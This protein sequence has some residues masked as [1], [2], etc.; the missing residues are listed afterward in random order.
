MKLDKK[1]QDALND[2][3]N[4]EFRSSYQ[5]LAAAAYFEGGPYRG[6]AKWMRFQSEEER[7]H[8]MKLL[9]YLV[10]RRAAVRLEPIPEPLG[11]YASPLDVFQK[12]LAAEQEV[13]SQIN[14][15]YAT[16]EGVGDYS[17]MNFLG[18]FLDE[19]VEEEKITSEMVDRL[20]LAGDDANAL[21][22]LDAEA[23]GR[24]TQAK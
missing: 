8:A 15:L 24:P 21:L 13:S 20:E 5:Y 3:V 22:L 11:K 14:T 19:Q 4:N 10:D 16:A 2:Q 1:V 23:G 9:D 6:F 7:T 17:T 12:S 18:W